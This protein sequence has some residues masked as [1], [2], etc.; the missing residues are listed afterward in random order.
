LSLVAKFLS[1]KCAPDVLGT[2]GYLGKKPEKEI[3]EAMTAIHYIRP[4]TLKEPNKY[5]V[6]DLCA[7]NALTSVIAAHLLPIE[8]AV[9]VDKLKRERNWNRCKKFQ[10]VNGDIFND[11]FYIP[12]GIPTIVVGIHACRE[13][14]KRIIQIYLKNSC[15]KHLILMPCCVGEISHRK[16]PP[17]ILSKLGKYNAWCMDLAESC[18]GAL[19]QNSTCLS[20]KNII[21]FAS[22]QF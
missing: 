3:S 8:G 18:H 13:L 4:L 10:Y 21:I 9:A 12:G 15:A 6:L 14:A 16:Y 2:V 7:G 22:K 1:L 20:P 11:P 17:F 19:Y 5:R